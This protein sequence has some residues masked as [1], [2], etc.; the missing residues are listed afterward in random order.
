MTLNVLTTKHALRISVWIL[1][2]LKIHVAKM[3]CVRQ[4]ATDQFV[5]AQVDGLVIPTE[6]VT[7]VGFSFCSLQLRFCKLFCFLR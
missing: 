7:N 2:L 5:G 4:Q 1:V 6:N 3:H